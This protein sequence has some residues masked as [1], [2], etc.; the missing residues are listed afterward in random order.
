MAIAAIL[1]C[2]AAF[3]EEKDSGLVSIRA[4]PGLPDSVIEYVARNSEPRPGVI[5]ANER[6]EEFVA[7]ICGVGTEAFNKVFYGEVN[8]NRI[9]REPVG[10]DRPV[11]IPACAK[12]VQERGAEAEVRNGERLDD[13]LLRRIGRTGSVPFLCATTANS[14][15]CNKLLRDLVQQANPGVDLN[16]LKAGQKIRLPFATYLT[17]FQVKKNLTAKEVIAEISKRGREDI[18]HSAL[19]QNF[20]APPV[21]L[22]APVA[23]EDLADAACL[24]ASKIASNWPYDSKLVGQVIART[25]QRAEAV[26][27][28]PSSTTL[29]IV[30]TGVDASFPENF[31]RRNTKVDSSLAFGIG[32]FRPDQFRPDPRHE[33]SE[34]RLHGTNV[35]AIA[36]GGSGL[37]SVVPDLNRLLRINIV[38]VIEPSGE[39]PD[40][41]TFDIKTDGVTRGAEYATANAQIANISIG[42]ETTLLGVQ[43]ALLAQKNFLLVTA[44]GNDSNVLGDNLALYPAN[45]GGSNGIVGTQVITVAAHDGNHT[46]ATFSNI[47]ADYVDLMA[48]GCDVPTSEGG[49]GVHGTSFAAPIVSMTA[50]LLRAFGLATPIEIKQR[51]RVSADYDE[52]LRGLVLWSGRLNIAKA[53]S[54]YDDVLEQPAG[55][56]TF[57]RWQLVESDVCSDKPIDA[58]KLRKVTR[59]AGSGS[60]KVVIH[61]VNSENEIK[62]HDCE[63][64]GTG[65]VFTALDGK[66][67]EVQWAEFSDL[68]QR[69]ELGLN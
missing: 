51:L 22:L 44:A 47:S 12:W 64:A 23:N 66:R 33:P 68:V 3:S 7:K 11:R 69:Q 49:P 63:P 25:R 27:N 16:A 5:R 14:P 65:F 17:T 58:V 67:I 42:S 28:P 46:R 20:M 4:T 40:K 2:G 1:S 37:R 50:A 56:L 38:N 32:T 18:L 53:L 61:Y 55:T 35:A 9:S 31:L 8:G 41:V 36:T 19:I 54:L 52:S 6:P 30:D 15:R 24:T 39:G 45:F 57:G 43:N 62:T 48:P 13:V 29:T 21:R 26:G 60:T 34:M 10:K 59:L